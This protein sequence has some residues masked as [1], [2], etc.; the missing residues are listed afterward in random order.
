MTILERSI[1]GYSPTEEV[2]SIQRSDAMRNVSYIVSI[3]L[4]LQ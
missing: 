4:S 1:V 2:V 3:T